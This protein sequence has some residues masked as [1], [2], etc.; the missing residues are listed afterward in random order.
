[1][2]DQRKRIVAAPNDPRYTTVAGN[3]PATGKWY[4]RAPTSSVVS[5]INAEGAWDVTTGSTSIVDLEFAADK[6]KFTMGAALMN[7][8][9]GMLGYEVQF[10]YVPGYF[11]GDDPPFGP[12]TKPGSFLIDMT[13]SAVFSLPPEATRGGLRPYAVVGGGLTHA[14]AADL[15]GELQVRRTVPVVNVGGG[16]IGLLAGIGALAIP[17]VGPLIAAGPIMAALS[18]FAVGAAVGGLAGA[19]VGM[20]IP[21]YV[22][23][24]YVG[25]IEQGNIL[26]SV[27]AD[28]SKSVRVAKQVLETAGAQD[29]STAGEDR[30]AHAA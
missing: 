24:R 29:I 13:A 17:G 27:H 6:K 14:Q 23:K 28:D 1:M 15:L 11:D 3:G 18:G 20:G 21:E 30:V 2:P 22:A 16:A 9:E 10:G 8:D 5:A 7:V 12:L 26:V 25:K 19:L 4:L